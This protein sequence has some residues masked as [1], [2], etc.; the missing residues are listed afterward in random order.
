MYLG[1][2]GKFGRIDINGNEL[3]FLPDFV[4]HDNNISKLSD[5]FDE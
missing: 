1:E 4:E 3:C 5:S 2:S